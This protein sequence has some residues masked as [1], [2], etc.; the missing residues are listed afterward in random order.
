MTILLRIMKVLLPWCVLGI[1]TR[2]L[3]ARWGAIAWVVFISSTILRS[4]LAG[5]PRNPMSLV[6]LG[7]VVALTINGYLGIYPW[8]E[9]HGTA[10]CY[11]I[12][13]LTALLS[14]AVRAPFSSAYAKTKV[15][16]ALWKHPVFVHVND[17]VSLAW[18]AVFAGNAVICIFVGRWWQ[19]QVATYSLLAAALAFSDIYPARV[20]RRNQRRI[21][22]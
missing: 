8:A 14:V 7:L 5:H 3:S 2:Y 13:A 16:Q 10:V 20:Q 9:Q 12:F 6:V 4:R 19:M 11:A 22:T 1:A 21:E 15:P 18:A 17:V